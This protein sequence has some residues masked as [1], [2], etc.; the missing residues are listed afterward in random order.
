MALLVE[1]RGFSCPMAYEILLPQ[2]G[3]EPTSAL[4]G[5]FHWTTRE[6]PD[7]VIWLLLG[8]AHLHDSLKL[9]SFL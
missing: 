3:I 5:R 7:L 2:P 6:V 8:S 9:R 4:E 1:A